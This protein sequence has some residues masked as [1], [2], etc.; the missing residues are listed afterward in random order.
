MKIALRTYQL[1]VV[2][3][4]SMI[5][6]LYYSYANENSNTKEITLLTVQKVFIANE[7]ILFEFGGNQIKNV[8]LMIEGSYGITSVVPVQKGSTLQFT[9]PEHFTRHKGIISWQLMQSG[10]RL[11]NGELTVIANEATKT[12]MESY[13]G[14]PSIVAGGR[15]YAMMVTVPTDSLD[16]PIA[17]GTP[18]LIKHQ[19]LEN[20]TTN[21]LETKDL[22]AWKNIFSY[23]KSGRILVSAECKDAD[24]KEF[25]TVVYPDNAID[26]T[27]KI[28]REHEFAD[29]NQISVL[30]TSVIRD[31][32]EN[33]VTDGTYVTF[34][35]ENKEGKLLKTP[36]LTINGVA[37]AEILHPDHE[38]TWKIRAYV[39]GMGKSDEIVVNYKPLETDYDVVIKKSG[40]E[41]TVGPLR[42]FMKQI[43]PDG[44]VVKMYIYQENKLFDYKVDTSLKGK[45]VF[46]LLEDFY[47]NGRYSFRIE[48]LGIVKKIEQIEL[49]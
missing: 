45:V 16:N 9:F 2:L 11:F 4:C 10:K 32:Y 48:A 3:L 43:I 37:R 8:V 13:L 29:G 17:E 22:I 21:D 27:I 39:T 14:P 20:I 5:I 38:E 6:V 12:K 31:Q 34:F 7:P 24:S 1:P 28:T 15:D 41:I 35:I 40:R 26:F 19:F 18:T 30:S 46:D 36:G 25:M 33:I 42:S 23:K 49:W 47:P 44:A